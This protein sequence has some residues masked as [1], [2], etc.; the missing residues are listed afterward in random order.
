L[1]GGEK[2][3]NGKLFLTFVFV[4]GIA[5]IAFPVMAQEAVVPD[6]QAESIAVEAPIAEEPVVEEATEV[7]EQVEEIS[8]E[9]VSFDAENSILV[10]K[11]VVDPELNIEK[12]ENF[13]ISTATEIK[14]GNEIV[15][16][17]DIQA[18]DMATVTCIVDA[19]GNKKVAGVMVQEVVP[20][21]V[22]EP[23]AE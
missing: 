1:K 6:E 17:S 21:T 7:T 13:D 2:M 19:D 20:E 5:L 15:A 12:E 16:F 11:Y 9:V 18:G 8:G 22:V 3:K 10:L 14:K 23:V 4:L